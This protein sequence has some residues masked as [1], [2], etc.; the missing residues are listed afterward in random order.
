MSDP[1]AVELERIAE[2]LPRYA[3]D[4]PRYTSYPT[5]PVWTTAYR[6]EDFRADLADD[7]IEASDGLSLYV[8]VPFCDSLCH[9]CACNKLITADHTRAAGFLDTI[10]REIDAVR[11][12]TR[13]PR[14]ATQL[15]W[16]GG[17]PT[18]LA[19]AEIQRLFRAT[20]EAFPLRADAE[21]SIEVDPRVTTHEHVAVLAECGFNRI[22]M[23]VQDFD[24][25]V[26]LAIHRIQPVDQT[27]RLV[28]LSRNAGFE[29]VNF[30]LIYGLPY[31]TVA[32]F[33]RTLD[34]L[35]AIGP[36]RI[37]LYSYAHVTWIAKQ[38]RGFERKDLPDAATKLEIMLT[39][40]RRFLAEGYL[41][42]GLD[43]FAREGDE[44]AKALA[45]RS[46]RRN[47]MG[48]TTQA[49]VDLIGFGPSAISELRA[50]YAQ[51][52]REV[53]AWE[54]AVRERGVATMRGHRLSRADIERRWII[55]RI[56]CL[57]ELR[58]REYEETFGRAFAEA[59]KPELA[60]L[61]QARGD[62]LI[63]LDPDGSLRVLPIGRLL[64]RPVAMAFDAYL[65]EQQKSGARIFSKIV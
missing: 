35:F 28:E 50:S 43:H 29:S 38:Q 36:D 42:I 37:A 12:A 44:L 61:E 45:D 53:P 24:P 5:A 49:G 11:A 51:S 62:G 65:A 27:A 25:R 19:P 57:G 31:Q 3:I 26:Q 23:G 18:W 55:N 14:A 40:V 13:V 63:E 59:Y 58:A 47:F 54:A 4:G 32:S 34:Q 41:F 8:H 7:Q 16:G 39:A 60:S 17:T 64:V 9:F 46:L 15:H 1:F 48:H 21:I 2:L 22:S 33:E 52:Q 56:L 30:D 20:T 10:E 6:P